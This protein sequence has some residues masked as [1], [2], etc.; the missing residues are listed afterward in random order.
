MKTLW[1]TAL[2][3]CLA[4]STL[5]AKP[6]NTT[7][8]PS[9]AIWY[10][11]VDVPALVYSGLGEK[12]IESLDEQ[13]EKQIRVFERLFGFN[14]L[15]D[16]E[17]ITAFGIPDFPEQGAVLLE[18]TFQKELLLDLIAV[19]DA[20][21]SRPYRNHTVHTWMDEN[22]AKLSYGAFVG[23]TLIVISENPTLI[24]MTLD[25]IDGVHQSLSAPSFNLIPTGADEEVLVVGLANF[26]K[27]KNLEADAAV[28]KEIHE[29]MLSLSTSPNTVYLNV[30]LEAN[31]AEDA[32][33]ISSVL[34]GFRALALLNSQKPELQ[35]MAHAIE[36]QQIEK[37]I[38]VRLNHT[39]DETVDSLDPYL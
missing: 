38:H 8:I 37:T 25:V 33:N 14:P 32:S 21:Q 12:L 30:V 39:I 9:E 2:S 10:A 28:L 15:Y 29:G 16:L 5:G 19:N 3:T 13:K 11:H 26:S 34:E 35:Q 23:E 7:R 18:G 22:E 27:M 4:Y 6:L 36:V 31:K 20:Y 24:D 17:G 1:L